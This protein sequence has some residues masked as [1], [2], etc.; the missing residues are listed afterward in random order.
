MN[1]SIYKMENKMVSINKQLNEYICK[2]LQRQN[3]AITL[4]YVTLRKK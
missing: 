1:K 4:M 3:K 2:Q